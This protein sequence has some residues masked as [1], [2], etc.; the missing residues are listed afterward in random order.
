MIADFFRR[1]R[2]AKN[3]SEFEAVLEEMEQ[4]FA[5]SRWVPVGRP[6]NRGTIEAASDPGR[7]LVERLTNGVDA[8]LELEHRRHNG[9]PECRS[10]KEA[11]AAWLNVP[12]GGLSEMGRTERRSL[13]QRVTIR[14]E[15]GDGKELRIVEI[16]DT[17][18]GLKPLEMPGTI[19]SLNEGNKL[20][21]LYLAG[22]Y[23]QGGSSTFAVS[24]YTLIASRN[25]EHPMTGFTV[26]K[27]ED[28]PP[29]QFKIGR[30]VYL[31]L[32]GAVPD[33]ELTDE[34]FSQGTLVRHY[35]YDL[36]NYGSP[37]GPS[38]VYGLLNQTL[39]DPVL[40]VWLESAVHGYRRVIKGARNA[41]NGAVDEGDEERA[42][43]ELKG[44]E[45]SHNVPLFY[46]SIAE[47]G[48][49]GVEYWVLK[50]GEKN[51][52]PSSA[53][54]NPARPI[55]LTLLG[56][57]HAEF[58]VSLIRKEAELPYLTQRMIAHVDCNT[59]TPAAKRLLFVS[60][61]EEARRG[62][63]YDLIKKEIIK[64]F[65]SDDELTR[66]NEEAKSHSMHERDEAAMQ[67]MRVEVA[68]LLRLQGFD[69]AVVTGGS[70][71]GE[72]E[73]P[74][75]GPK[76][77][78]KRPRKPVKP[79]ES[80]EPPT[81]IKILW[82]DTDSMTFYP[83]QR[84]YVR[85]ETDAPASYHNANDPALSRL[86]FIVTNMRP[87]SL[88]FS[89]STPL[90]GGRMRAIFEAAADAEVG[91]K[92]RIRVELSRPGL[93]TLSDEREFEIVKRPPVKPG[94]PKL[95][96]PPFAVE[97]VMPEDAMWTTLGWP[98]DVD[99]VASSAQMES[100]QLMIYYSSAFPRFADQYKEFE[101]RDP[102]VGRGFKKRYETWL[103]VHS[104]ILFQDGL[105][106]GPAPATPSPG[107]QA[108]R[109][110]EEDNREREE[111]CRA[112]KLAVMFAKREMGLAAE[113]T[114][115]D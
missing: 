63:V 79:I 60:N 73:G 6:N 12:P 8:I 43:Q 96:V 52:K 84:R 88:I 112:A 23:G 68:R 25:R 40:P 78:V 35:G 91:V 83:E 56:Q 77:K 61:R 14:L 27:F 26:V 29:D 39:F 42:G 5:T 7:S 13:A 87:G 1:L 50:G 17:G 99:A 107:G 49:I 20:D 101:R 98:E 65:R 15:S 90:Q 92:G 51:K 38:S 44:P 95:T 30:Y 106:A 70:V 108:G 54:V 59:L 18:T 114:D 31:T 47:F 46:V 36:T 41:L 97:P 58:P 93:S 37:L 109:E 16:R 104:L 86:N 103:A 34:E 94:G 33:A 22:A 67:E 48:R 80:K 102:A 4:A 32:D 3:L 82:D 55:V 2:G 53:F 110:D 100:G 75:P 66:L 19:L 105:A 64:V 115:G 69:L 28:L 57:N 62:Q 113:V 45:L 74:G 21:K 81:F 111:R 10:P 11:A 72:G 71:E 85:I 24:R 9:I 89:G 76:K